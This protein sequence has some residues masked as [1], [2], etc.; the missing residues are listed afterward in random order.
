MISLRCE[1]FVRGR[2]RSVGGFAEA[3]ARRFQDGGCTSNFVAKEVSYRPCA[4]RDTAESVDP[5]TQLDEAKTITVR[6]V[7]CMLNE[8]RMVACG[9]GCTTRKMRAETLPASGPARAGVDTGGM[10]APPHRLA[11][12]SAIVASLGAIP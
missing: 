5:L 6:R 4:D 2:C 9:P 1:S 8:R 10:E 11:R 7:K 12:H 3:A